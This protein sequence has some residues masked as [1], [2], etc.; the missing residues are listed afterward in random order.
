MKFQLKQVINLVVGS[1]VY[2]YDYNGIPGNDFQ[3]YYLEQHPDAIV[4]ESTFKDGKPRLLGSPVP[5]LTNTQTM[6]AYGLANAGAIGSCFDD[7]TRPEIKGYT[8]TN[9]SNPSPGD[10]VPPAAPVS[11]LVM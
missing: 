6:A 5:D 10:T 3:V 8:C 2:L 9:G 7:T 1:T 4:P 11:L